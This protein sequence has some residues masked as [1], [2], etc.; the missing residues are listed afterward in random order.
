MLTS[1]RR[2]GLIFYRLATFCPQNN[3]AARAIP[4]N[5]GHLVKPA[6]VAKAVRVGEV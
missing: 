2:R 4:A 5:E 6:G 1:F 3:L